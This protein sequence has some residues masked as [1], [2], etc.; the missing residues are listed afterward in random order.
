MDSMK[1]KME[2]E[3]IFSDIRPSGVNRSFDEAVVRIACL[4]D[5]VNG[6]SFTEASFTKALPT[7]KNIPIVALYKEDEHNYGGHESSYEIKDGEFKIVY[8]THPFGVI[9]ESAKQWYEDVEENGVAKKY[10]VSECLLWKRQK[11]YDLIKERGKFSVSMEIEVL[12][13]G[14]DRG[15]SIYHINDFIFTAV[16]VLGDGVKPCFQSAEIKL[17]SDNEEY[18]EMLQAYKQ[19]GLEMSKGGEEMENEVN[20]VE[21][22]VEQNETEEVSEEVSVDSSLEQEGDTDPETESSETQETQEDENVSQESSDESTV[23]NTNETVEETTEENVVDY[24]AMYNELQVEYGRVVSELE[25]TKQEFSRLKEFEE[26]I[27]AE[28]RVEEEAKVFAKFSML[29]SNQ[30]FE[31]IKAKASQFSLNELEDMCYKIV[32]RLAFTEKA[33]QKTVKNTSVK[34][35]FSAEKQE[36]KPPYYGGILG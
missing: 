18:S 29:E 9:H 6:S 10:L 34:L 13:G 16:A 35:D 31:E 20:V 32:G 22:V 28:K 4:G 19:F 24:E 12:N 3:L 15:S 11:S 5:N 36:V 26:K 33:K 2:H 30:E 7:L 27:L 23:E 17:F 14:F 25:E 1:T 8:N 21:T